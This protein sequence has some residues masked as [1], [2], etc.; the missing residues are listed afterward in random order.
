MDNNSDT[1]KGSPSKR[2]KEELPEDKNVTAERKLVS[3]RILG[4]TC[5]QCGAV[6]TRKWILDRHKET[7]QDKKKIKCDQCDQSFTLEHHLKRHKLAVHEKKGYE[8]D[9]CDFFTSWKDNLNRHKEGEHGVE[10]K[11]RKPEPEKEKVNVK[12]VKI[13]VDEATPF[14]CIQCESTF[15]QK[16]NLIKHIESV[17]GHKKIKCPNCELEF[18][19]KDNLRRHMQVHTR[20]Q[21]EKEKGQKKN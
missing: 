16:K 6:F 1:V 18:N 5:K 7:V 15:G 4:L 12:K 14:Q 10:T 8:C 9:E 19:R 21:P 17:H 11:K 13:E 3:S 20:P 2:I